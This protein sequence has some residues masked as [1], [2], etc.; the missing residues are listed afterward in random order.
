MKR[1]KIKIALYLHWFFFILGVTIIPSIAIVAIEQE[2]HYA[3]EVSRLFLHRTRQTI[4]F[5]IFCSLLFT[6][7]GWLIR[8]ILTGRCDIVPWR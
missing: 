5:S 8:R 4:E 3:G 1:L 6:G 2:Y 7:L